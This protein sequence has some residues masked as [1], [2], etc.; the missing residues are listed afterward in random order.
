MLQD[1]PQ[2]VRRLSG[3]Q[4]PLKYGM[5][6]GEVDEH[7]LALAAIVPVSGMLRH[8]CVDDD[9]VRGWVS[10]SEGHVCLYL[11]KELRASGGR[12]R[13]TCARINAARVLVSRE[14]RPQRRVPRDPRREREHGGRR[15]G[16]SVL[17]RLTGE[18]GRSISSSKDRRS[19]CGRV[20]A[21]GH[22]VFADESP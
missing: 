2:C 14:R 8:V 22:Q 17:R 21:R 6:S 15:H 9:A 13:H 3:W 12:W 11:S 5:E 10:E 19:S 7:R 4:M 16:N 1:T 20:P 18:L